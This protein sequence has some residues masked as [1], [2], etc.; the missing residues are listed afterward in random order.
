MF[1]KPDW[2]EECDTQ[3]TSWVVKWWLILLMLLWKSVRETSTLLFLVVSGDRWCTFP[4]SPGNV[5]TNHC[6]RRAVEVC[7]EGLTTSKKRLRTTRS[8]IS[9]KSTCEYFYG[10]L[11]LGFHTQS[12]VCMLES[13]YM[14]KWQAARPPQLPPFHWVFDLLSSNSIRP[15]I[16]ALLKWAFHS[17][18]NAVLPSCSA[19]APKYTNPACIVWEREGRAQT[20]T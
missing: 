18:A 17:W 10:Q 1:L 14:E 16:I 12:Q 7:V 19:G 4:H 9:F 20:M 8:D 13:T 5:G 2:E 3:S 15:I 6:W 11:C